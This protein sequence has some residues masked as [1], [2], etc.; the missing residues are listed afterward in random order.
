[1][2]RQAWW[3][4]FLRLSVGSVDSGFA[5]SVACPC[6]L[7]RP[8]VQLPRL[9]APQPVP[10]HLNRCPCCR[11]NSGPPAGT[12]RPTTAF[13][14]AGCI[15][16]AGNPKASP[17]RLAER[18]QAIYDIDERHSVR[19][20]HENPAVKELYKQYLGEPNS[21]LAHRLLHTHYVPGSPAAVVKPPVKSS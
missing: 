12:H 16:G 9:G 10:C 8:R 20:S 3:R 4:V 2:E 1:M 19:R 15:G 17:E 18:Q 11:Q 7:P 14:R 21:E 6:Q 13:A 5:F